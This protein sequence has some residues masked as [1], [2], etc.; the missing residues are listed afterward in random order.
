MGVGISA[1]PTPLIKSNE[2]LT[3]KNSA[4]LVSCYGVSDQKLARCILVVN[5]GV[6]IIGQL[7]NRANETQHLTI[8]LN[9]NT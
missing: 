5:D 3:H 1:M 2:K 8:R 6:C 4:Q 9:Q 7:T